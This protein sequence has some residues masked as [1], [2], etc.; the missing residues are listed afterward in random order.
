MMT[1]VRRNHR[2]VRRW[3]TLAH[4]LGMTSIVHT[5]RMRTVMSG[6][7]PDVCVLHL[8]EEWKGAYPKE[9]TLKRLLEALREEDFNDV[10]G[11]KIFLKYV[12]IC[13]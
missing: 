8:L 9:A 6:D 5:L 13:N 12:K 3:S 2:I 1:V 4:V 7:D 11:K 10:A